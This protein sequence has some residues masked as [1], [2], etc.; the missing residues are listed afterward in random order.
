MRVTPVRCVCYGT[1]RYISSIENRFRV[2]RALFPFAVFFLA[3]CHARQANQPAPPPP[4]VTVSRPV[5]REVTDWD[6][7]AGHLQSPEI[8]RLSLEWTRVTAPIAGRIS[9]MY[10]TAGNQVSATAGQ[11]TLLTTIVSVDPMYCYVSV[12][13]RAFLRYQQFG[14][15]G[16]DQS[17]HRE[18][19]PC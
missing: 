2:V 3:G 19:I 6:E 11:T 17:V 7:Y 16:K 1:R 10:V 18:K 13:E 8:A 5:A 9:R 15:R 12:P 14:G 4:V